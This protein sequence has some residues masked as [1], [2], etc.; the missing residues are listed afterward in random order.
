MQFGK[1]F[2]MALLCMFIFV[3]FIGTAQANKSV[4]IISK[5]GSPSHAQ[6][7]AIDGNEVTYQADVDISTLNPGAGPV[8]N[9]VWPEKELMFV[10]YEGSPTIVWAS[11][12]TLQKVGELDTGVSNLAGIVV[13]EGNEKIYVVRRYSTELYVYSWDDVKDTIVLEEPNDPNYPA[14]K[15]HPLTNTT[16]AHGIALDEYNNL[17]Y[18]TDS[19]KTVRVYDTSDWSHDHS[20]DI[21]V[22]G[23]DRS[24][25]GIAVDP[26]NGYLYTGHWEYHN[27]LVRTDTA[28]PYTSTEVEITRQG[29]SPKQVIGVDVDDDT[30]LVYI[31]TYHH[32]FRVYDSN[33]VLKDTER[34]ADI[35]GPGGVAVGGL[36]KPHVF[37]VNKVDNV[38]DVDCVYPWNIIE[39][40]YL[41][42]NICYDANGYADTNVVITDYLPAEVE[43]YSS[44]SDP[45]G[46]YH[47]DSNTVTWDINDISGAD[48]NCLELTVKVKQSAR[49]G[50]KIINFCVMEGD[51]Y[52][53][54]TTIVTDIC[55]YGGDIIY[56]DKDA[57]GYNIGTSWQ[58]A[59]PDL[60][61]ALTD[62]N[63][64]DCEQIRVAQQTYKPT[65]TNERSISFEMVDDVAVYGGFPPGGG[66][67]VE[68][69][70]NAYETIL[71][72]D[73]AAPNN[74]SDNSYHVV[75]CEDVNNAILDGFTITGGNAKGSVYNE[76]YGGGVYCQDSTNLTLTDCNISDNTAYHGG[77]MYNQCSSAS[78]INCIFTD[79]TVNYNGGGIYNDQSSPKLINCTFTANK[80]TSSSTSV[81]YH[82]GAIFNTNSSDP[83]MSNCAFSNNSA[84]EGGAVCNN[85]S[86]PNI[87]HCIF[88][89]NE[90]DYYGGGISNEYSSG[91]NVTNCIFSNNS[92]VEGGAVYNYSSSPNITNCIFTG[93]IV[94]SSGG[95][96]HNK[97]YSS[98]AVANCTFI[99]NSAAEG[100]AVYNDYS[101]PNITNCIFTG[102]KVND[103]G[104]GMHNYQSS[105]VVVSSI[106]SGNRADSYGGGVANYYNSSPLLTNCTFSGNSAW[107]GGGICSWNYVDTNV[108]N[109]I[110][111][112]ND[113]NALGGEIYN[114]DVTSNLNVTY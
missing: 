36:Y 113:A 33:L 114:D 40:N 3:G 89:G 12:K 22:S 90:A 87:T 63:D 58:N 59:Y 61:D 65:D 100:G 106:F 111:W 69:D 68:R 16:N 44:S 19:S 85:Y 84:R 15:Y 28:S 49:P 29:Y 73:I 8:G 17:L 103:Y 35:Y 78:L 23:I 30:G 20:I 26:T 39:E 88:S 77:G 9:A 57:N 92:S 71:S 94:D 25:V 96:M 7:Y 104:G 109:C 102:N 46:V 42:Y 74:Q 108:T 14:R 64:C 31:T 110:F 5:H 1:K 67:W 76:W 48:S 105:P 98:V 95:G 66:E 11:T 38:N 54:S 93:N 99:N 13:D 4:F 37:D 41:V 56:V 43:Y 91:P 55:C 86:K 50:K 83:N 79:N 32:D 75:K 51:L 21:S 52:Y 72:G 53:K 18:I 97:Y 34:N 101:N 27:Y 47:P 112:G 2:I 24:A 45:C 6:A 60:Q 82:G 80:S 70:P 81:Y 10:T 107:Y 62:A